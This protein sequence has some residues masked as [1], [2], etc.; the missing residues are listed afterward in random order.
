MLGKTEI[1]GINYWKRILEEKEEVIGNLH[2][3][4]LLIHNSAEFIQIIDFLNQIK[5]SKHLVVLYFSLNNSWSY[6]KRTLNQ[7]PLKNKELYVIDCVSSPIDGDLHDIRHCMFRKAPKD[8]KS[9]KELILEDIQQANPNI[10]VIDSLSQF[11]N[12]T[13]PSPEELKD[14]YFFLKGINDHV[15]GL[16]DDAII[17]LYDDKFG[18]IRSMPVMNV[19]MILKYEIIRDEVQWTD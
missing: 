5:P 1:V 16:S 10:F 6:I 19:D 15:S 8:L 2:G 14:V 9:L 7:K 4:V 17:L 18:S 12:F 3:L 11:I 13:S